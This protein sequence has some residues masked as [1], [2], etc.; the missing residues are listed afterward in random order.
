MIDMAGKQFIPAIIKYVTSLANSINGIK[1]ASQNADISVQTELLDKCSTLL[2]SAQA[3]LAKLK[4]VTTEAAA[5]EDDLKEQAFFFKD[6]VFPAMN[7]LRAPIDELE[8]IVDQEYWPVP[9]YGDL[10]F[11]V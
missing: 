6:V 4:Q 3:A 5:K 1:A 11:E 9:T 8:M 2:A 7:E 10:L